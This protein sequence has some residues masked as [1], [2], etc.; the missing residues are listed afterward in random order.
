MSAIHGQGLGLRRAHLRALEDEFPA[1][2]DFVEIAPENWLD[3]GGALG[4]ALRAVTEQ[5]PVVCHGLSLNIGG[6]AALDETFLTR[7]KTFLEVHEARIYS[8]HLSFCADDGHLYELM[9]IPFTLD[10]A[11]HVAARVRRV[12]DF[13]GRRI[14]LENVSYYCAPGAEMSEADFIGTVLEE[15]DC[16]LLLDVNNVYVNGLN[17]GYDP[18]AFLA[19]MPRERIVYAHV[20]GHH[21]EAPDLVIDTHGADVVA[22][23]WSLLEAA[24]TRFG[25]IPTVLERDANLPPFAVLVDEMTRI[26]ATQRA[27]ARVAA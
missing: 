12:Q 27:A 10:A 3:L 14:A 21:Q 26:G 7:L 23:V 15:A 11:R 20:A 9:P 2:I 19:R 25:A 24:Y 5:V 8:E 22:P 17:H 18:V 1:A 6:T 16:D 4:R 13:L